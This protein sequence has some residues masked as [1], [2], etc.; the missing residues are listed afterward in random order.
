ML[1]TLC[2]SLA[3]AECSFL[4]SPLS[5]KDLFKDAVCVFSAFF[6]LSGVLLDVVTSS[7]IHRVRLH[8]T[9]PLTGWHYSFNG[10]FLITVEVRI[11]CTSCRRLVFL[12]SVGSGCFSVLWFGDGRHI[13]STRRSVSSVWGWKVIKLS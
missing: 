1:Y 12:D 9:L 7:V 2:R 8:I 5:K 10:F 11:M 6:S 4:L 3:R 13:A